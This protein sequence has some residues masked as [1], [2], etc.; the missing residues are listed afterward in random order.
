M[1][2]Y[3]SLSVSC[4]DKKKI[5]YLQIFFPQL[6]ESQSNINNRFLLF[7]LLQLHHAICPTLLGVSVTSLHSTVELFRICFCLVFA[8]GS[9][10]YGSKPQ[11]LST[12]SSTKDSLQSLSLSSK[13]SLLLELKLSSILKK[14]HKLKI[15]I[16]KLFFFNDVTY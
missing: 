6:L 13:N 10:L 2:F 9:K 1:T 15:R 5:H 3:K 12:N 16:F 11:K 8:S 4:L 7:P 14:K